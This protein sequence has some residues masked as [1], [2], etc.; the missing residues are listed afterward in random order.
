ME[1][2]PWLLTY[3]NRIYHE[4]W[5]DEQ[6][7]KETKL[8]L[9]EVV[10]EATRLERERILKFAQLSLNNKKPDEWANN[11]LIELMK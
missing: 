8:I 5:I 10:A 9:E 7:Y 3:E 11:I 6:F 4:A 2:K 1:I